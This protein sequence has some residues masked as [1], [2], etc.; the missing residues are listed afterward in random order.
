LI[1]NFFVIEQLE[2]AMRKGDDRCRRWK[3]DYNNDTIAAAALPTTKRRIQMWMKCG[4]GC[5]H[6]WEFK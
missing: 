1:P 4:C 3:N 5:G 2:M 6:K